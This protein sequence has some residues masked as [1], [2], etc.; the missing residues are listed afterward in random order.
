MDILIPDYYISSTAERIRLYRE[1][2]EIR[3]IVALEVFRS[4]L[5]DRFGEIPEETERMFDMVSLKW[6]AIKIG[7]QK[8]VIKNG[9]FIGY[10]PLNQQSQ[11]YASAKF[12]SILGFLQ[13]HPGNM[14][15]KELNEKLTLRIPNAGSI[16]KITSKLNE[17]W[18]F[19]KLKV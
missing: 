12:A 15:I 19:T 9:V 7:F 17:I 1:L 14:Q 13:S 18:E 3:D 6:I 16:E 10:F 2:D 8:I 11:Y 5:A 4:N